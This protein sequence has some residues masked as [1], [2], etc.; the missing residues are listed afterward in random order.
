MLCRMYACTLVR[1]ADET[2]GYKRID[3]I[4]VGDMVLAVPEDGIGKAVPKRVINT[5]KHENKAVWHIGFSDHAHSSDPGY[6]ESVA[7]TAEHPFCVYGYAPRIHLSGSL[8]PIE[9]YDNPQWKRV[10]ELRAGDVLKNDHLEDYV[11][12]SVKPLADATSRRKIAWLQGGYDMCEWQ[13]A[14]RGDRWKIDDIK[15]FFP[16]LDGHIIR[17][18]PNESNDDYFIA[19]ADAEPT[20]L[21]DENGITPR[22]VTTGDKYHPYTTTVYNIEVEDYHTYCVGGA[23]IIVH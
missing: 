2:V 23:G 7:A 15:T 14:K 19:D 17:L 12:R 20:P 13:Y 10:D 1:M 21:Y 5:F 18:T 9:F 16:P 8:N 3:E 22:M 4:Q 11:V 6:I